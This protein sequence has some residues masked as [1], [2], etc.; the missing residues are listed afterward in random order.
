MKQKTVFLMLMVFASFAFAQAQQ[1]TQSAP[2]TGSKP[3]AETLDWL[4]GNWQGE[5]LM[6]GDQEFVGTMKGTR[7]LDDEAIVLMR[8]S[9]N[10]AGGLAGGRKEIMVI[11]YEGT[12]KKVVMTLH[13]SNNFIGIY[14]GELKDHEIVFTLATNQAGYV[15]RRSFKQLPD[16]GVSFIIERGA[17][18]K[19]VSKLVEINFKKKA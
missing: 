13:T 5:G 19:N 9:M 14:T 7:E 1:P 16:G 18:G 8:E 2:A 6:S 17:P 11:G 15:D 12:T 3:L 4:V 10:K